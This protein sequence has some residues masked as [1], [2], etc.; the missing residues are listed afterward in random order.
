M[1]LNQYFL[2]TIEINGTELP[3]ESVTSVAY[4]EITKLEAPLLLLNIRDMTGNILDNMGVREGS[5]ITATLGDP[6]GNQALFK[7]EFYVVSAPL[8]M[9]TVTITSIS[10]NMRTLLIPTSAPRFFVDAQPEQI[11]TTLVKGLNPV[12]DSFN[13]IGT[14]HLNMGQKPATL[15]RQIAGDHGALAWMARGNINVKSMA[16]LLKNKPA[17]TYEYN[18]PQAKYRITKMSNINSD[19]AATASKQ[20]RYVGYS[21]TEGYRS[22]GDK[23]LPVRL[24]PDSDLGTL[25]N[26]GRV[27]IPK[28]DIECAGNAAIKAGSVIQLLIHRYDTDNRIDESVPK[29]MIVERVTQFE[30]RFAYSTRMILGV[31]SE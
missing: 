31:P 12:A 11:I 30:E 4:I 10:M 16:G 6:E 15:L 26:M 13:R 25:Q 3:R 24:M 17:F 21:M 28:L 23:S 22:A 18:N 5:V 1:A 20:H 9:D 2:Q 27:L 19:M 29:T 8:N 14:Y 7:E